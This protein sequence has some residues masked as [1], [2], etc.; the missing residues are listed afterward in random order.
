MPL[1]NDASRSNSAMF[2]ATSAGPIFEA[3]GVS[4]NVGTERAGTP[5][6]AS[7]LRETIST[8]LEIIN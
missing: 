5:E 8:A 6:S 4:T 7:T 2:A 3:V 1:D